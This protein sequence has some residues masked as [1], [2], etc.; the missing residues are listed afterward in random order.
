[1]FFEVTTFVLACIGLA[2]CHIGIL[3][4]IATAFGNKHWWWAVMM[5]VFPPAA[6]PYCFVNREVA[7]WPRELLLLGVSALFWAWFIFMFVL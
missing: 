6:L 2:I 7:S 3:A 5:F 1:M 4:S